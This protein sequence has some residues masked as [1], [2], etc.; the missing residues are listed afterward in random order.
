M[1][2]EPTPVR[3]A[4]KVKP[5]AGATGTPR[6]EPQGRQTRPRGSAAEDVVA[7][8]AHAP[9]RRTTVVRTISPWP[10]FGL[11]CAV[12]LVAA[13]FSPSSPAGPINIDKFMADNN[14]VAHD[15]SIIWREGVC[16]NPDSNETSSYVVSITK[17][18]EQDPID[19]QPVYRVAC[20]NGW[21]STVAGNP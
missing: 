17:T 15:G 2:P 19:Y 9:R 16:D 8:L 21:T 7:G 14:L 12:L 13:L 20:S 18:N 1:P 4:H 11:V 6:A 3:P 10:W 5:G